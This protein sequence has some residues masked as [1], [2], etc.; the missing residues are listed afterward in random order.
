MGNICPNQRNGIWRIKTNQELDKIIK[1]KN[2]INFI[3]VQRLGWLGHIERMQETRMVKA[4]SCWKTISRRPTGR[5]K[6][7]W[8]NNVRKNI[9][10]SKVPNWKTL[11]QDRKRW[12]ELF[13]KAKTLHKEL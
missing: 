6:K 9:Q 1:H 13:E 8:E 11:V 5:P 2:T 4:M 10:K 3:R 7:R 12:K